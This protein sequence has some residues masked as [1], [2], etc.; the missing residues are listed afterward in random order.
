MTRQSIYIAYEFDNKDLGFSLN[1]ILF[2]K[3][4]NAHQF[5]TEKQIGNVRPEK[6]YR[7]CTHLVIDEN[8]PLIF[9]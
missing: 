9:V 4:L 7:V 8:M 6:G 5:P 3:L 1:F 2:A